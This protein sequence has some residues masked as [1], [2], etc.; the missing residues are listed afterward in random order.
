MIPRYT[1]SGIHFSFV[2]REHLMMLTAN[3][4]E[5]ITSLLLGFSMSMV[6]S[7]YVFDRKKRVL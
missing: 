2:T 4:H 6:C 1:A 7:Y 5:K 3:K